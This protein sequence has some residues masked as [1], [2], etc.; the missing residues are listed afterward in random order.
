MNNVRSFIYKLNAQIA[1]LSIV[2]KIILYSVII[3]FLANF[4]LLVTFTFSNHEFHIPKLLSYYKNSQ[5][6]F[7]SL[8]PI[9]LSLVLFLII[10]GRLWFSY[11]I[12]SIIFI[13]SATIN[14]LKL[15]YRDEM[16]VFEDIVLFREALNMGESYSLLPKSSALIIYLGVLCVVPMLIPFETFKFQLKTKLITFILIGLSLFSSYHFIYKDYDRFENI[17]ENVGINIWSETQ[18]QQLRG[19]VYNFMYSFNFKN[20]EEPPNYDEETTKKILDDYKYENIPNEQKVN[21]VAIMLESYVDFSNHSNL[22]FPVDVYEEFK[23]LEENSYSGQLVT[24]TFG[25]G[26]I[27]AERKFLSGNLYVQDSKLPM[28]SFVRYFNEQGYYTEAMHPVF[29]WFYNRRN[30]NY[31]LGFD[32]FYYHE[33]K[34][35]DLNL[36]FSD[37]YKFFNFIIEEY[38]KS[39][40]DD[41]PYFNFS[42][43]YQNHGPYSLEPPQVEYVHHEDDKNKNSEGYNVVNNFLDGIYDTTLQMKRLVDYFEDS[44]EPVV[45][46]FFGDHLPALGNSHS[47]YEYLGI[48]LDRTTY[49]GVTNYFTVPYLFYGNTSAKEKLGVDFKG[50]GNKISPNYL[51]PELFEYIGWQGNEF[52]QFV[53]DVKE[54]LPVINR[55]GFF[56]EG[57]LLNNLPSDLNEKYEMYRWASY[58]NYYN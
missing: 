50:T 14:L 41:S 56:V 7:Y 23:Y 29:G 8:F 33:N 32:N 5:L 58:Y 24:N 6:I 18:R 47:G 35:K 1:K 51:M 28:N 30:I 49:E 12:T 34:F 48:N 37:D 31:N 4:L 9:I 43:T 55:D 42:V 44:N 17:V 19:F 11:L 52:M 2:K 22:V 27:D 15:S 57:K 13:V 26:T 46:I 54:P 45:I 20:L 38:E 39:L 21:I 25:G 40:K 10:S 3:L 53:N 36:E 16:F